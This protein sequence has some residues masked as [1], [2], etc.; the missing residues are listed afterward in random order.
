MDL[1]DTKCVSQVQVQRKCTRAELELYIQAGERSG[2]W[3][4]DLELDQEM[5]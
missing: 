2:I 4:D 1:A 5:T 3:W